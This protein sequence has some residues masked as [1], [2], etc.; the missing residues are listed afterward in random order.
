MTI[1]MLVLVISLF[2]KSLRLQDTGVSLTSLASIVSQFISGTALLI[3]RLNF[4]RLNI[5]SDKLDAAWRILSAYKL[6][7][8]QMIRELRPLLDSLKHY[9]LLMGADLPQACLFLFRIWYLCWNLT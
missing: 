1:E 8:C 2:G 7:C 3:Y 4:H 6:N 9:L 5:T